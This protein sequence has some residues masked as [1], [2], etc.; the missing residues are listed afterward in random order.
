MVD[1]DTVI[2]GWSLPGAYCEDQPN[3]QVMANTLT[4]YVTNAIQTDWDGSYTS[5]VGCFVSA[6]E[7]F[8]QLICFI[9]VSASD[10]GF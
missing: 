9:D 4:Q 10:Y 1:R 3:M 5:D 6:E 7:Y 2:L 8:S